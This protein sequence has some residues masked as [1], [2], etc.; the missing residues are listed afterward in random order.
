MK[1]LAILTFAL[2]FSTWLFAG[3]EKYRVMWRDSPSSSIVVGW[4]QTGGSNPVVYYDTV[5]HGTN[6]SAYAFNKSP[7]RSVSAKGMNN[8]FARISGLQ[9]DT[10]YYFVIRDSQGTSQRLWFKTASNSESDFSIVA[11]GDSRNNQI[12]RRN[13]NTIVSKLRP[14]FVMFGGDMTDNDTN[15]QWI[16]ILN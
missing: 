16:C 10:A 15:T 14:L 5:D 7:D 2:L 13:A 6:W 8:N 9:A 4:N 1:H 11:G 12:P 3:T